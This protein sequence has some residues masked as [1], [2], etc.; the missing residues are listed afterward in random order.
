MGVAVAEDKEGPEADG[1][2]ISEF[3][4]VAVRGLPCL[5]FVGWE[6]NL[7]AICVEGKVYY[8]LPLY[9]C[10]LFFLLLLRYVAKQGDEYE[11]S[12]LFEY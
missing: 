3:L 8:A 10:V 9:V 11:S 5:A 4:S 1:F 6:G 12:L 2:N 7:R